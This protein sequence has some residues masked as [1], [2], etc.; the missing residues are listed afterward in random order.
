MLLTVEELK[1]ILKF[2]EGETIEFKKEIP[3]PNDLAKQFAAFSNT[4]GGWL[5]LKDWVSIIIPGT[6]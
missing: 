4:R 1:K 6:H 5:L 2:G 3:D